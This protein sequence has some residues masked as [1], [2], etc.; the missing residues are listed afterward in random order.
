MKWGL[1]L[2]QKCLCWWEKYRSSITGKW[3]KW[4]PQCH[5]PCRVAQDPHQL[6]VTCRYH[7]LLFLWIIYKKKRLKVGIS[8][9]VSVNI[10]SWTFFFFFNLFPHRTKPE[11]ISTDLYFSFR[12]STGYVQQPYDDWICVFCDDRLMTLNPVGVMPSRLQLLLH[13]V[14]SVALEQVQATSES[15]E[16]SPEQRKRKWQRGTGEATVPPDSA[17]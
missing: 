13:C 4:L 3:R 10:L 17:L 6:P 7:A 9:L 2:K 1:F 16:A 14:A 11:H 5:S 8:W 12:F 15:S